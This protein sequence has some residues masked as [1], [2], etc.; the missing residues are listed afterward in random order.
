MGV[1]IL[2]KDYYTEEEYFDLLSES[3]FPIEW[4]DGQL[5]MM[6]GG[7]IPHNLIIEN[8]EFALRLA[9]K[10]CKIKNSNNAVSIRALKKYLFPDLTAVCGKIEF[11]KGGIAR[12]VNP[13]LIIEVLSKSTADYD[14]NEKF[15]YYRSLESFKEYVLIDSLKYSVQT[16][17]R[18]TAN[19]WHIGSYYNID[20]A[21]TFRSLEVD[22]PMSTIYEGVDF[23][24]VL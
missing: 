3:D 15:T 12:I 6:S 24:L 4:H 20:Q 18:E 19:L 17:Y 21:V 16:F 1:P 5:H 22:I 2:D 9:Q 23:D 11:E 10:R 7:K 13:E 14:R 8:I